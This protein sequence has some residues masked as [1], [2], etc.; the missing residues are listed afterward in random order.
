MTSVGANRTEI[1]KTEREAVILG[2]I[3]PRLRFEQLHAKPHA[4]RNEGNVTRTCFESAQFSLQ[5]D[6]PFLWDD[7]LLAARIHE[8]TVLHASLRMIEVQRGAFEIRRVP[9][10][11]HG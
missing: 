10:R 7:Q 1:R 11:K 5:L 9:V 8:D 2:Y 4:S 6:R 3:P